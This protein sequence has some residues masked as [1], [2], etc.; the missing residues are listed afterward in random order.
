[1]DEINPVN[2]SGDADVPSELSKVKEHWE[3]NLITRFF[4]WC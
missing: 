1:M 2:N 3:K 4:I